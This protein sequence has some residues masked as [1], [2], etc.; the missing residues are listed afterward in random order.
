MI[1]QIQTNILGFEGR[2][3]TL[4]SS[5]DTNRRILTV[6]ASMPYQA[7]G[8]QDCVLISNDPS[9]HRDSPFTD[10]D[11]KEAVSA[12]FA[13]RDG[14]AADGHSTRLNFSRRA[15]QIQPDSFI[16]IEGT[17]EKGKIFHVKPDITNEGV[18]LLATCRYALTGDGMSKTVDGMELFTDILYEHGCLITI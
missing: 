18:A 6:V 14:Y 3:C 16:E 1:Q 10:K 5:Y 9:V 4:F 7:K 15:K 11:M 17:D 12:Y 2:P 8:R 13:I